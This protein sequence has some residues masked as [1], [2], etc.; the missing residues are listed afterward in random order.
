MHSQNVV[1]TI[2]VRAIDFEFQAI[3]RIL[4]SAVLRSGAKSRQGGEGRSRGSLRG[5][6]W[7]CCLDSLEPELSK[8]K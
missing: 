4:R 7:V 8:G 3:N 6:A 1:G 5:R 2:K